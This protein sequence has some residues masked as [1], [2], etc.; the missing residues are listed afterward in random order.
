[1][2]E[3]LLNLN[4]RETVLIVVT[5]LSTF[6]AFIKFY[7]LKEKNIIDDLNNQLVLMENDASTT[8]QMISNIAGVNVAV[9]KK[10]GDK[11]PEIISGNKQKIPAILQEIT[12]KLVENNIDIKKIGLDEYQNKIFFDDYLVSIE[13]ESQFVFIGNFLESVEKMIVPL[14][15]KSI[16]IS[17]FENDLRNCEAKIILHGRSE[18]ETK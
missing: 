18:N 11:N 13:L 15:V 1:M 16:K 14:E 17:R 2:K 6:V 3:Q 4:K 10:L 5:L 8:K 12:K 9:S 7:Y